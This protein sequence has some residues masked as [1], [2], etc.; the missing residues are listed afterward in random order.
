MN[1]GDLMLW[2]KNWWETRIMLWVC[3]VVITF[4][5]IWVMSPT[6]YPDPSRAERLQRISG[7][8][9]EETRQALPS[10]SSFQGQTWL[11]WFKGSLRLI[12]P[13][14][15]MCWA[16]LVP[17]CASPWTG[18]R[19]DGGRIF[20]LSLPVSRRR[21]LLTQAAMGCGE[22]WLVAVGS[23]LL[24]PIVSHWKGQWYSVKDA[25]VFASLSFL[26]ALV[27]YFL[28]LLMA[29]I[30]DNG[31]RAL[32]VCIVVYLAMLFTSGLTE[33]SP[34]WN[35]NRLIAGEDYFL[36]GRI[37]WLALIVSLLVSA[38]LLFITVRVFERRDF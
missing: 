5:T 37:P 19:L 33:S 17:G 3:L 31:L 35:I 4:M 38:S 29:V 11:V 6:S 23:S 25:M 12:L 13:Y 8:W 27:F 36:H 10:L 14:L 22:L 2:Q 28:T 34:R 32:G 7:R 18:K 20:I 1:Q 24:L 15:A 21:I 16:T 30:F 9:N 26:G